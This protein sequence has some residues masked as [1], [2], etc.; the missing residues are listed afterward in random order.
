MRWTQCINHIYS[1]DGVNFAPVSISLRTKAVICQSGKVGYLIAFI[2]ERG[3]FIDR[4]RNYVELLRILADARVESVTIITS[5]DRLCEP[6]LDVKHYRL[7]SLD[8]TAWQ[9]FFECRQ[10]AIDSQT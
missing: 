6:E 8:V 10:L 5:R 1:S 7:P 4:H 2:D 9:K 3:R